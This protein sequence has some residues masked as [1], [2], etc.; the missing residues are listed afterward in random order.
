MAVKGATGGSVFE[1]VGLGEFLDSLG[2]A[3]RDDSDLGV[4]RVANGRKTSVWS[5]SS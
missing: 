3:A 1:G 5:F 4:R 2:G